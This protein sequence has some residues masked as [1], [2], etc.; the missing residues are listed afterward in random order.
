MDFDILEMAPTVQCITGSYKNEKSFANLHFLK[1]VLDA[2]P[3]QL[4]YDTL[5]SEEGGRFY[6]EQ[7]INLIIK[8]SETFPLE[9][10]ENYIWMTL[11]QLKKFILFNNYLNIQARSI[12]SSISFN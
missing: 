1:D 12:I 7:N 8:V 4:L 5:Q 6:R 10:P 2:E 11:N 9:V 3:E